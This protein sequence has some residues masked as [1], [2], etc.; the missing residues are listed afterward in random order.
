MKD[1]DDSENK[2]ALQ[3]AVKKREF[4]LKRLIEPMQICDTKEEE[5]EGLENKDD[6]A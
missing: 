3:N 1:L 4:L 5:E 6:E 2:E